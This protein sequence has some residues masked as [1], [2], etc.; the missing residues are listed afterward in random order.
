L[1][2]HKTLFDVL[3]SEGVLSVDNISQLGRYVEKWSVSQYKSVVETNLLSES[4][5]MDILAKSLNLTKKASLRGSTA[6]FQCI[7]KF[8]Q[9]VAK[10]RGFIV[11][12]E[13]TNMDQGTKISSELALSTRSEIQ[14]KIQASYGAYALAN[15]IESEF[16]TSSSGSSK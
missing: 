11:L 5:L 9:E 3:V 4:R 15:T 10:D 1:F 2:K 6:C 14:R 13:S 12:A 7:G 8:T 16:D